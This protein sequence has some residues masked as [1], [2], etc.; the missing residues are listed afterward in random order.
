[1]GEEN[2]VMKEPQV[3][4]AQPP[5]EAQPVQQIRKEPQ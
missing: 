4:A 1:M 5:S 2:Q 3:E